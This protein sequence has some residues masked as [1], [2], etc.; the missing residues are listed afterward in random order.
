MSYRGAWCKA[1]QHRQG[2]SREVNRAACAAMAASKK[3]ASVTDLLSLP[4]RR[5]GVGLVGQELLRQVPNAAGLVFH[6]LLG[7]FSVDVT[8]RGVLVVT[9]APDEPDDA[10]AADQNDHQH[11]HKDEDVGV[12]LE[13]FAGVAA[14]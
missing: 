1:D 2:P 14:A 6:C 10:A 12:G 13:K 3:G 9:L 7:A 4:N 11:Y 5:P 8:G